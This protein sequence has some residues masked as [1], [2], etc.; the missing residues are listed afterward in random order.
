MDGFSFHAYP[1]A[2]TDPLERGYTWPNAGFAN[3]D[4]VKQALWDAFEGTAQPTTEKGLRL[5]LD[6]VGWQ[7]DTRGR[8]G[9]TGKE[10][11]AVTTEGRQAGLYAEVVRRAACDPDIAQVNFFGLDDDPERNTGWQA[12][13]HW[14][15][16][17][18]KL[19]AQAVRDV[20]WE[21]EQHGCVGAPVAWTPSTEVAGAWVGRSE[22]T[23]AGDRRVSVSAEE[24]ASVTACLLFAGANAAPESLRRTMQLKSAGAVGCV[25]RPITRPNLRLKLTLPRVR[26]AGVARI[27]VRFAAEANGAR[28]SVF[29]VR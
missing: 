5:Y 23:R 13:L 4:R 8:R 20:I 22:R 29:V 27:G 24:G 26:R 2:H 21:V 9:Y 11:V 17:T 6:E 14:A 7:V 25:T 12:A 19:A 15:D 3:L 28:R 18:P 1:N 16:G 10:N